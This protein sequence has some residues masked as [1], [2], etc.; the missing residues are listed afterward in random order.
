[1]LL[2]TFYYLFKSANLPNLFSYPFGTT[3]HTHLCT[4][5]HTY[6]YATD[7]HTSIQI[8]SN[9]HAYTYLYAT[10]ICINTHIKVLIV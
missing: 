1:M 9:S 3:I 8:H 4:Y 5:I 6:I 2:F 7:A 10:S